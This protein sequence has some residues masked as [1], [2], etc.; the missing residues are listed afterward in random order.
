MN[1]VI[2]IKSPVS[3]PI[4]PHPQSP[5]FIFKR[6]SLSC[7]LSPSAFSGFVPEPKNDFLAKFSTYS[8]SSHTPERLAIT[9]G[10]LQECLRPSS[11]QR[12]SPPPFLLVTLFP[13]I[14]GDVL[15]YLKS[16]AGC[17]GGRRCVWIAL[18]TTS[19]IRASWE[20]HCQ[21]GQLL[22]CSVGQA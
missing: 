21:Q 2:I 4:F 14:Q 16:L 22:E 12:G 19:E 11:L 18:V 13:R 9:A 3:V 15:V 5:L 1:C 6:A 17:Q 7:F 10:A 8:P 20:H